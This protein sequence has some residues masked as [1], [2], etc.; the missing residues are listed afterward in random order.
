MTLRL[1]TS[2]RGFQNFSK[3]VPLVIVSILFTGLAVFKYIYFTAQV[4][5]QF[6]IWMHTYLYPTTDTIIQHGPILGAVV[7]IAVSGPNQ[8]MFSSHTSS[9]SQPPCPPRLR[10]CPVCCWMS[11]LLRFISNTFHRGRDGDGRFGAKLFYSYFG[12]DLTESECAITTVAQAR[13]M[14]LWRGAKCGIETPAGG[15]V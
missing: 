1:L 8:S 9:R 13:A 10:Q 14:S 7:W 3:V 4:H 11:T 6:P 2:E 15:I 12:T 5:L